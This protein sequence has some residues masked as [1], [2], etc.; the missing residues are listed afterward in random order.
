M[1]LSISEAYTKY[2]EIN[3]IIGKYKHLFCNKGD[4]NGNCEMIE[5]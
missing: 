5:M 3:I 1:S 4:K 2:E